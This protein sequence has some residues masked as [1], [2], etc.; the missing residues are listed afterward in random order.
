VGIT[1]GQFACDRTCDLICSA[2]DPKFE[3][4]SLSVRSAHNKYAKL[5]TSTDVVTFDFFFLAALD[6]ELELVFGDF[7]ASPACNTSGAAHEIVP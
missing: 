3:W 2:E 7:V 5:Y 1:S 6:S 4:G